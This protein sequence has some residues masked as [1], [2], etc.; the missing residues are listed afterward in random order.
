MAQSNPSAAGAPLALLTVAGAIVGGMLHQPLLGALI[1]VVAGIVIAVLVW[2][3]D[4]K[5]IGH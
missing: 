5:K 4:R 2:L 3:W 1:G